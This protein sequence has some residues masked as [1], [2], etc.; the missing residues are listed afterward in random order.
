MDED[1]EI[2]QLSQLLQQDQ[3]QSCGSFF[4]DR[5]IY[6]LIKLDSKSCDQHVCVCNSYTL[7]LGTE[8]KVKYVSLFKNLN[9]SHPHLASM[10]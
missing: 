2:K 1:G 8:S 10:Y 9:E 6:Y 3:Q 7:L 4:T 5:G